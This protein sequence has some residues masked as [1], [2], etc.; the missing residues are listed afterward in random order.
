MKYPKEEI[1]DKTLDELNITHRLIGYDYIKYC[2]VYLLEN[3]ADASLTKEI[4]P[5]CARCYNCSLESIDRS[6]RFCIKR[7]WLYGNTQKQM[8]VFGEYINYKRTYP[9]S[10]VLISVITQYILNKAALRSK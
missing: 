2:V 3:D 1:I 7:S 10:N 5:A 4:Y 8:E 6:I 9:S